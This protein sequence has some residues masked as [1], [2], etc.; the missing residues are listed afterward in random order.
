MSEEKLIQKG[1]K[2]WLVLYGAWIAFSFFN[3][4]N[5]LLMQYMSGHKVKWHDFFLNEQIFLFIFIASLC[6][7][8]YKYSFR[9]PFT[10]SKLPFALV[11]HG[12][13]LV[14]I[15]I[16]ITTITILFLKFVKSPAIDLIVILKNQLSR[17]ILISHIYSCLVT[18]LLIYFAMT[19]IRW[20]RQ[21]R[22]QKARAS[23]LEIEASRLESQLVNA[24]LQTLERQLHPHFLFNA[25]NSISSLV[26]SKKNEQAFKTIAQLSDLLRTSI[27][28][29]D[30]QNITLQQEM[31]LT[32]KYLAIEL[33]R[34]SDRLRVNTAIDPDCTEALVPALILQPLVENCIRHG[35]AKQHELVNIKITAQKQDLNVRL[36]IFND[37][38]SL[39]RDWSLKTNAGVGINNVLKRLKLTYGNRYEFDIFADTKPGVRVK[40]V[41]PFTTK[42]TEKSGQSR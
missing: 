22:E 31:D 15:Y 19:T 29:P 34:F 3:V 32:R 10:R 11:F 18:Y 12:L 39:P 9:F 33:I 41:F 40:L 8:V 17:R 7:L 23:R 1:W 16:G 38:S 13:M 20:N 36:E 27:D 21:R 4:G 26:Q 25:L 14:V 6:P 35:V 37:R 30:S 2:G 42:E 24:K 5:Y 28:L